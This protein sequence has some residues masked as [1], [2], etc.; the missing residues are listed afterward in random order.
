MAIDYRSE[1]RR[2]LSFSLAVF[3]G[4]LLVWLVVASIAGARQRTARDHR[5]QDLETRQSALQN[6]LDQQRAT[7]GTL[8]A[9]QTKIASA[10]QLDRDA[11]QAG[12]QA[13]VK[14]ASLAEEQKA[15]E[16][17]AS[18]A[19]SASDVETKKL[20]DL[21]AQVGQAEQKLAPMRDATAAAEQAATARTRELADVGRRL[22]ETRQQEAK[23]RADIAAMS[24][25][26]TSKTSDLA[27]AEESQQKAREGAAAALKELSDAR[28]QAEQVGKQRSDLEQSI[29]GL[30]ANRDKLIADISRVDERLQQAKNGLAST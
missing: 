6:D 24:Q 17:E 18:V 26:A 23:L 15:A 7:A 29:A 3:A 10:Q 12:E 2:P 25:E 22:E 14:T 21:Q 8:A 30:T 4:V 5:I 1:L 19:K 16:T 11:I 27:K 13:K 9:L 20:A 28:T